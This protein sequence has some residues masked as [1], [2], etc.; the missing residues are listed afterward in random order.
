MCVCDGHER[1]ATAPPTFS[2]EKIYCKIYWVIMN[3]ILSKRKMHTWMII[4]KISCKW[5]FKNSRLLTRP[6]DWQFHLLLQLKRSWR[7]HPW[8]TVG[9]ETT[10]LAF[11]SY[12]TCAIK[13]IQR[14][15]I[16]YLSSCNPNTFTWTRSPQRWLANKSG[17]V[18]CD[19]SL[20]KG[21]ECV[22]SLLEQISRF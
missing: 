21:E 15:W 7:S 3:S 14:R 17:S 1:H 5:S 18:V 6:D 22:P 12:K 19:R 9:D 2:T 4:C 16:L 20:W 13:L 11:H 8:C 10:A